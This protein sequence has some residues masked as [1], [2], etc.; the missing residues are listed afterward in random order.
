MC[1]ESDSVRVWRV[2]G[3]CVECESVECGECKSVRAWGA[4]ER[5][6]AEILNVC[7]VFYRVWS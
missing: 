4:R 6:Y 7:G 3:E 2:C 1:E 5:E